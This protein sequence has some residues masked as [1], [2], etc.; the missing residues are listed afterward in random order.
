M[1]K[2]SGNK[3]ISFID[4]DNLLFDNS[5]KLDAERTVWFFYFFSC[6]Y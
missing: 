1:L 3:L 6:I 5:E 2:K 4:F